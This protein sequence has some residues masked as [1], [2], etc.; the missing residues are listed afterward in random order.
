VALQFHPTDSDGEVTALQPLKSYSDVKG[1]AYSSLQNPMTALKI[2]LCKQC[3][4]GNS[5]LVPYA[6]GDWPLSTKQYR[7]VAMCM[8]ADSILHT[9]QSFIV[10]IASTSATWEP[11]DIHFHGFHGGPTIH[12]AISSHWCMYARTLSVFMQICSPSL[13]QTD[14]VKLS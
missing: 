14:M 6:R 10:P 9:L 12:H 4:T 3:G 13:M 1:R 5:I 2:V 7:P 11:L 8:G